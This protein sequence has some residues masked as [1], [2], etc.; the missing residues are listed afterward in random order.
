MYN[1]L[2]VRNGR[3]INTRP[4]DKTGIQKAC[5]IKKELKKQEKIAV[6]SEAMYR[7]ELRAD[8]MESMKNGKDD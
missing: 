5:E 4:N 2:T 8:F 6:M 1:D 7:A 3:L